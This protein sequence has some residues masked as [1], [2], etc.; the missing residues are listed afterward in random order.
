MANKNI[1]IS[2]LGDKA[3]E[4]VLHD[5]DLKHQRKAVSPAM[6]GSA[7]RLKKVVITNIETRLINTP[8]HIRTGTLR[9]AFKK[10]AIRAAK[11]HRAEVRVGV[12]L[13]T[14][15][16]LGDKADPPYYPTAVEY[17]HKGPRGVKVPPYPYIRPAVDENRD[18]ELR[19]IADDIGGRVLRMAPRA[20]AL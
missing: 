10:M 14:R 8:P 19:K 17:G 15:E 6:R 4:K 3:L 20:K 12:P 1:D 7:K 2:V 5:L 18:E 16:L 13:P 9:T 11:R